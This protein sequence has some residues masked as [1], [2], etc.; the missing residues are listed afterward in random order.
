VPTPLVSV[1]LVVPQ[2][3]GKPIAEV[4]WVQPMIVVIIAFIVANVVGNVVAAQPPAH[5]TGAHHVGIVEEVTVSAAALVHPPGLVALY[6]LLQRVRDL[7][8][9]LVSVTRDETD[10]PTT[11]GTSQADVADAKSE[12]GVGGLSTSTSTTQGR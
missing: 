12:T 9:P 10:P 3:L 5:R 4:A 6:G 2:V 11:L 7:G 1:A 8:L